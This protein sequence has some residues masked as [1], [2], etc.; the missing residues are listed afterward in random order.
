MEV[1]AA[2]KPV[3]YVVEFDEPTANSLLELIRPDVYV[4]GGD[5]RSKPLP[6]AETARRVG[7]RLELVDLEAGQ[8]TTG[9]I[10]RIVSRYGR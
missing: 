7:A 3:D 8:S 10:E 1:I 5:Y 2:L 9:I 6:E 4:K